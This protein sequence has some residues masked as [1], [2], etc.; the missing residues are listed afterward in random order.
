MA[1]PGLASLGPA[2]HYSQLYLFP[3]F[4]YYQNPVV[5]V[6]DFVVY[7]PFRAVCKITSQFYT[8]ALATLFRIETQ[9]KKAQEIPFTGT[10][11][12]LSFPGYV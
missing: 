11:L 4:I 8:D 3:F 6:P 10:W 7:A 1:G 5:H 2:R 9:V 12:V